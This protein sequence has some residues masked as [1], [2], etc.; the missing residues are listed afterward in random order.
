MEDSK[1]VSDEPFRITVSMRG[2]TPFYKSEHLAAFLSV[3]EGSPFAPDRWSATE[4]GALP[5]SRTEILELAGRRNG[6]PLR[7]TDAFIK[8]T[9]AP[10]FQC[11]LS[12]SDRSGFVLEANPKLA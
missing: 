7:E 8:R 1:A 5:Y 10:K 2:T 3:F 6:G 11:R 4:R 12:L 9:K